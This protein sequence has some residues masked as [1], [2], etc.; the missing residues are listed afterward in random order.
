VSCQD[1]QGFT[2]VEL[3]V[4]IAI[5][6]VLAALGVA[7]LSRAIARGHEAQCSGNLRQLGVATQAYASDHDGRLPMTGNAPFNSPP[8][9]QP[10]V[11][12]VNA[13]MKAGSILAVQESG[14]RVFQ[15]PAYRPP[16][17][18]DITYAPNV[19]S[20]NRRIN[21]VVRP[22]NKIWLLTSTDS[23]SVNGSGL[24]RIN[25]PHNGRANILFFD[26]HSAFLDRPSLQAIAS[27]AFNP[28]SP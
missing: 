10:L 21:Q 28:A 11:P 25:F 2:L 9:Y 22:A 1:R 7:G 6:A 15:C 18:R 13:Q 17:A 16:P 26:G 19:M 20:A 27:F 24:Q 12:Y 14:R 23:F 8:W 5:L 3:L 4:T